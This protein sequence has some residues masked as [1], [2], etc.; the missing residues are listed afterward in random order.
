MKE[1]R[2]LRDPELLESVGLI[3]TP[4][5][6]VKE[7]FRLELDEKCFQL[8]IQFAAELHEALIS[9]QGIMFKQ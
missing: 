2:G 7:V 5:L 8:Q 6:Y 3:Q 9:R 4:N 1:G